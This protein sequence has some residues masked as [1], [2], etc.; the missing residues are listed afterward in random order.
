MRWRAASLSGG[1][2]F[3]S[4]WHSPVVDSIAHL[5]CVNREPLTSLRLLIQVANLGSSRSSFG[6]GLHEGLNDLASLAH[7]AGLGETP[8]EWTREFVEGWADQAFPE[9]AVEAGAAAAVSRQGLAERLRQVYARDISTG[10]HPR[11]ERRL[12]TVDD[13]TTDLPA[14][15]LLLV[16]EGFMVELR[17]E[18]DRGETIAVM[19]RQ[20]FVIVAY[21]GPDELTSSQVGGAYKLAASRVLGDEAAVAPRVT[22][23]PFTAD[24]ESMLQDLDV[25]DFGYSGVDGD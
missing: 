15:A 19:P 21:D 20:L 12:F 22:R 17:S 4:D 13:R 16:R 9:P 10:S 5:I 11:A 18:C 25:A 2:R 8:Q 7:A 6:V 23:M 1:W 14:H 3:S 24:A